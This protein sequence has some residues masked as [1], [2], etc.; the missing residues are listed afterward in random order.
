VKDEEKD[1]ET[2]DNKMVVDDESEEEVEV[3]TGAD[4]LSNRFKRVRLGN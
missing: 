1:D 2:S 3:E 4:S